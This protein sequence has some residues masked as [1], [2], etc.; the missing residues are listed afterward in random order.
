MCLRTKAHR[1]CQKYSPAS[2][3]TKEYGNSLNMDGWT[4]PWRGTPLEGVGGI[5]K[6]NSLAALSHPFYCPPASPL[7][8]LLLQR[9]K[10]RVS[11]SLSCLSMLQYGV[12]RWE[13]M[14]VGLRKTV[15]MLKSKGQGCGV[16]ERRNLA[17]GELWDLYCCYCTY[18]DL[19]KQILEDQKQIQKGCAVVVTWEKERLDPVQVGR[20]RKRNRNTHC[21]GHSMAEGI[22]AVLQH[23][24]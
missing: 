4:C 23:W 2:S 18:R 16:G 14:R 15:G 21:S 20:G 9:W 11:L 5:P 1:S 13:V 8:W 17:A 6:A 22:S 19:S 12:T 7:T 10:R 24:P 3:S